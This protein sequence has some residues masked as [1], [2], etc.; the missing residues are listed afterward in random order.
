MAS[1]SAS[2]GKGRSKMMGKDLK[3][4][5]GRFGDIRWPSDE[6]KPDDCGLG[7]DDKSDDKKKERE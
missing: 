4:Y 6:E 1:S 2:A 3:K 7:S 5:R